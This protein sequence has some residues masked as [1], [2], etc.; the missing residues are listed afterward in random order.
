[1]LLGLLEIWKYLYLVEDPILQI[2]QICGLVQVINIH[3]CVE[4]M[5]SWYGVLLAY[6]N[7]RNVA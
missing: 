2:L 3:V 1:M 4:N 7:S 5:K 6:F